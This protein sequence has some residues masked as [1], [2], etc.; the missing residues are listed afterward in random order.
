MLCYNLLQYTIRALGG[1]ATPTPNPR[2]A[3]RIYSQVG[4]SGQTI[5]GLPLLSWEAR[6]LE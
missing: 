1:G 2:T 6:P 4:I 3:V 5:R